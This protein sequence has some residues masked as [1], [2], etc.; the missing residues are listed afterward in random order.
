MEKMNCD[1]IIKYNQVNH[2]LTQIATNLF[3]EE[4]KTNCIAEHFCNC[5]ELFAGWNCGFMLMNR[6]GHQMFAE[7]ICDQA[8]IAQKATCCDSE[9]AGALGLAHAAAQAAQEQGAATAF[10][11]LD[12]ACFDK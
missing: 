7:T 5:L 9:A 2:S 1:S 8:A 10:G 4:T 11:V 12:L 3:I 6:N